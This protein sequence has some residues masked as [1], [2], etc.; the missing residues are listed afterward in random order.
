MLAE[1]FLNFAG[2]FRTL[3]G[4]LLW[5]VAI[6]MLLIGVV[7]YLV[8]RFLR[9]TRGARLLRGTAVILIAL[10]LV[11]RLVADRFDLQRIS[12]LYGGVLQ[13]IFIAVIVVFAPEL[14]R[15]L[16]RLGETR[17][18]RKW[19][20]DVGIHIDAIVESADYLSRRR[21]GAL[22]AIEREVGLGGVVESGTRINA[23]ISAP[24]LNSIFWPNSPLHDLG[25]VISGGR[26]AYAA[27]QFPLAESGDIEQELGSRHR[28]AVGLSQESDAVIIVVS[29]QTGD[30]SVAVAGQLHRKL[31]SDQLRLMLGQLLGLIPAE[32]EK[33]PAPAG[34][35]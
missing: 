9:G 26:I 28:A 15:V 8:I 25:V 1:G 16:M 19:S 14:R 22:L 18:F 17:L 12:F 20:R 4:Y 10:Y 6:E 29:E 30:V 7:V 34:A 27:V 13:F 24:L 5:Q 3:R 33:E 21:I 32:A 2:F 23:D 31:S 35:S 11:V